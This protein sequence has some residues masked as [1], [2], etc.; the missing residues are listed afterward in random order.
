MENNK[1][2][3]LTDVQS[4]GPKEF[5]FAVALFDN[6]SETHDELDFRKGDVLTVLAPNPKNLI[7]WWLCVNHSDGLT[8]LAPANRLK[9]IPFVDRKEDVFRRKSWNAFHFRPASDVT[10]HP[11]T[12]SEY[13]IPRDSR[14][15]AHDLYDIP[16]SRNLFLSSDSS[17]E[18]SPPTELPADEAV[19]R[20]LSEERFG[21]TTSSPDLYCVPKAVYFVPNN[22]SLLDY[23]SPKSAVFRAPLVT[24]KPPIA[25]KPRPL[26]ALPMETN[27][28]YDELKH[29][30]VCLESNNEIAREVDRRFAKP[31]Q[32]KMENETKEYFRQQARE[33]HRLLGAAVAE[34]CDVIAANQWLVPKVALLN[35]SKFVVICGQKMAFLSNSIARGR[36]D[37]A[38]LETHTA[39]L[40]AA[41]RALV[42]CVRVCS[43]SGRSLPTREAVAG[44]REALTGVGVAGEALQAAIG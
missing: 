2:L 44:V 4:C 11:K 8:G 7:G 28:D 13:D 16:V 33:C 21:S 26:P 30:Y 36:S 15:T 34:F 14:K 25:P 12:D 6:R 10:A 19:R 24:R 20:R 31:K 27:G 5:R 38:A 32:Q 41:L 23:D 40:G 1:S 29:D 37:S 3:S 35:H 43:L 22:A 18:D 9:S 42:D 17:S 39:G